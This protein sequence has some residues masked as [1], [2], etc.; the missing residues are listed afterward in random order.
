M[1]ALERE[2]NAILNE[3]SWVLPAHDGALTNFNQTDFS[4]DLFSSE[5]ASDLST[6]DWWFQEKLKPEMRAAI[7]REI[8]RRT[9]NPYLYSIRTGDTTGHW[10]M[11]SNINWNAVCTGN[12]VNCILTI[13]EDRMTRA[14]VLAS[15][16][17]SDKM[18]L[19]GFTPDGYCNEGLGYWGY[20]FGHYL[21]MGEHILQATNG[22]MNIFEGH[23]NIE[24]V[25][26]FA[27]NIQIQDGIAPA[28]ADC[29]VGARPVP[30]HLVIIQRHWPQ[31]LIKQV[32]PDNVLDCGFPFMP[33]V[34]FSDESSSLA[35]RPGN[36]SSSSKLHLFIPCFQWTRH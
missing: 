7:R 26:A 34:A 20:G 2:I 29:G 17:F 13:V 23:D 10:W 9:V 16:E 12:M 31:S 5:R 28:F 25:A 4:V 35:T 36:F 6:V 21:A 8:F 22:K 32:K 3:K 24:N 19:S 11:S 1:P 15:T 27:K 18:F 33:L 14:E 30:A